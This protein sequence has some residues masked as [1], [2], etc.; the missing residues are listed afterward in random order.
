MATPQNVIKYFGLGKELVRIYEKSAATIM[1]NT[2]N[3]G[4]WADIDDQRH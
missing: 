2:V 4:R 3:C 1:L